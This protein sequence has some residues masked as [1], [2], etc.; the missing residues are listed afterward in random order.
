[1]LLTLSRIASLLSVTAP[2]VPNPLWGDPRIV[3]GVA[4]AAASMFVGTWVLA[5]YRRKGGRQRGAIVCGTISVLLHILLLSLLPYAFRSGGG[6]ALS[7]RSSPGEQEAEIAAT[8]S[9]IELVDQA[10]AEPQTSPSMIRH[11]LPVNKPVAPPSIPAASEPPAVV[12][13]AVAPEQLLFP[14]QIV[15]DAP[16]ELMASTQVDQ[17]L[18]QWLHEAVSTEQADLEPVPQQQ[19]DESAAIEPAT[20]TIDAP[21]GRVVA[22]LMGEYA[23]RRGGAKQLALQQGG[24]DDATE[25]AVAAGIQ[26]LNQQQRPDGA[27]DPKS[28]GAGVERSVLGQHRSGAGARATTGITGL[29]LLAM[30]GAG[31]THYDGPRADSVRSGL[32]YLLRVQDRDGSLA[33][34]ADAY[35]RTYCHGMAG[36]AICEAAAMTG[37]PVAKEAAEA[38]VGFTIRSQHPATG[39]W[40]YVPGDPGD[41][42]QLGW[43]AML[44]TSGLGS[45]A[46]V[47]P[48]VMQRVDRFLRSVRA[49]KTGGLASYK[50]GEAPSRTMTAEALAIRMLLGEK[51]PAAEIAE[52][53][54]FILEELPGTGKDNYYFW[55][56]ASLALHQIQSDAW[57]LW[58]QQ[59]KKRLLE[60]QLPDGSWSASTVWG[61]H[62]GKVYTTSMACLCLE[63]YYRH[64]TPD[65]RGI[66]QTAAHSEL[67]RR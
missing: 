61:G 12:P 64:L 36:I 14:P 5:R 13:S 15:V 21:Q 10:A 17:L 26:W 60:T 34:D 41:L 32:Q 46:H 8:L 30:L 39:G 49:G 37:D 55:Y 52:A 6:R 20:P 65:E 50:P 48:E 45:G 59:M 11:P 2:R 53:Q 57:P 24:G 19:P 62:G 18:E 43:Q 54:S 66:P 22:P 16:A 67:L 23:K 27:W 56:Y 9:Q 33:A 51:I 58:N 38:A 31:N 4:I 47:P 63:V 29:A 35:A 1:M 44:L 28:S 7:V 40:R 42:S 25:A 3:W